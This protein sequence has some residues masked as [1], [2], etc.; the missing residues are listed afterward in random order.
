MQEI[1]GSE[2]QDVRVYMSEDQKQ[3]IDPEDMDD[4]SANILEE[5][6]LQNERN[7]DYEANRAEERYS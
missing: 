1:N 3:E 7:D 2:Y 5:I 6:D 4:D